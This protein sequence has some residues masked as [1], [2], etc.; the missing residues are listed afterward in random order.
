MPI[1]KVNNSTVKVLNAYQMK[2]IRALCPQIIG[3]TLVCEYSSP[4][5]QQLATSH[6]EQ[7]C[8]CRIKNTQEE[9]RDV[10]ISY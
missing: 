2:C 4:D 7:P 9:K 5:R 8:G 3:F 10:I 1:T 6:L